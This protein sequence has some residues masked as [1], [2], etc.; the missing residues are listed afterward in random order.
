MHAVLP[1]MVNQPIPTHAW[2][3]IQAVE[4]EKI[5]LLQQGVQQPTS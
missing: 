1:E 2:L 4:P 5:L 3:S